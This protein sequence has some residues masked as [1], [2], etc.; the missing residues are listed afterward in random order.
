MT[1]AQQD[2]VLRTQ[3]TNI[4]ALRAVGMYGGLEQRLAAQQLIKDRIEKL[5]S[6]PYTTEAA[7]SAN[8][9]RFVTARDALRYVETNSWDMWADM[10]EAEFRTAFAQM[11]FGN[12]TFASDKLPNGGGSLQNPGWSMMHEYL[13]QIGPN[14]DVVH[15]N[16]FWGDGIKPPPLN[17][18]VLA[19]FRRIYEET[20]A[21]IAK[22][23]FAFAPSAKGAELW[24]NSR[25]PA[26]LAAE[27]WA[28]EDIDWDMAYSSQKGKL[29]RRQ[30]V[31]PTKY[32]FMVHT[33]GEKMFGK[34]IKPA[35][36][37]V[38]VLGSAFL[39][40]SEK[41]KYAKRKTAQS[42]DRSY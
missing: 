36:M 15:K 31:V 1:P 20:Q 40:D 34:K 32:F 16:D 6:I 39:H 38:T 7:S 26:G 29:V 9:A 4:H 41:A 2:A 17:P 19:K 23:P 14:A 11:W 18:K 30:T 22:D 37:E 13:G 8:L 12:G 24:R 42:Y 3:A 25:Q 27:S 10:P 21:E 28:Q 33:L 5:K 35:E